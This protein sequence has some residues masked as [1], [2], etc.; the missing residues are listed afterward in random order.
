MGQTS[1]SQVPDSRWPVSSRCCRTR[2][3]RLSL[4]AQGHCGR[5]RGPRF[6]SGRAQER[7]SFPRHRRRGPLWEAGAA[8]SVRVRIGPPSLARGSPPRALR[9]QRLAALPRLARS[10]SC[11]PTPTLPSCSV[12]HR[13][14]GNRRTRPPHPGY[15]RLHQLP[16]PHRLPRV[17]LSATSLSSRVAAE[18]CVGAAAAEALQAA[19]LSGPLSRDVCRGARDRDRVHGNDMTKLCS[20]D[21]R[22]VQ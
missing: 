13:L 15:C 11:R 8:R 14:G 4:P 3:G 21:I 9:Q 2:R 16:R 6:G 12:A 19:A 7:R 22:L 18:L 20:T 1:G 17:S 10:A 5:R